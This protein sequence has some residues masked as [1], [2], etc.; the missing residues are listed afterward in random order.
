MLHKNN[1]NNPT[2]CKDLT[3]RTTGAILLKLKQTIERLQMNTTSWFNDRI[4]IIDTMLSNL[5]EGTLDIVTL[6]TMSLEEL[7]NLYNDLLSE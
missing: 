5:D 2:I 6:N 1:T 7:Q 3:K 4:Q